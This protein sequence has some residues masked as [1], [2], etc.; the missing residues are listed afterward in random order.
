MYL[1]QRE[2]CT[3]VHNSV[4]NCCF[5]L[6]DLCCPQ[7]SR[8]DPS[9]LELS[10]V[11]P[12]CPIIVVPSCP[13][14]SRLSY[15]TCLHLSP[16]VHLVPCQTVACRLSPVP[17]QCVSV[18]HGAV[19]TRRH[20]KTSSGNRQLADRSAGDWP[21]DS[22]QLNYVNSAPPVG[23]NTG[24]LVCHR[25]EQVIG[26]VISSHVSMRRSGPGRLARILPKAVKLSVPQRDMFT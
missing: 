18:Q 6:I 19:I 23:H 2:G 13:Q 22:R 15:Q 14:L 5:Q 26:T 8:V 4:H 10:L 20:D 11:V 3:G 17:R 24:E 9:C 12:S 21:G 16:V 25:H 7:L 1:Q